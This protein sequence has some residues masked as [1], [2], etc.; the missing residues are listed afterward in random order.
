MRK[1]KQEG[2]SA[3]DVLTKTDN[4][5]LLVSFSPRPSGV[6]GLVRGSW[7]RRGQTRNGSIFD[8]CR[9]EPE[10]GSDTLCTNRIANLI[11]TTQATGSPMSMTARSCR[12]LRIARSALGRRRR[13]LRSGCIAAEDRCASGVREGHRPLGGGDGGQRQRRRRRRRRSRRGG[14]IGAA[15]R[16]DGRAR[17][18]REGHSCAAWCARRLRRRCGA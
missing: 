17:G 18:V 14:R 1:M 12:A 9:A 15:A 16:Q 13:Q 11:L 6:P 4:G 8:T 5:G 3:S 10:E 7:V 2:M